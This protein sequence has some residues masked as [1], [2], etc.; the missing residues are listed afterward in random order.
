MSEGAVSYRHWTPYGEFEAIF[1]V[2]T[3]YEVWFQTTQMERPRKIAA[4]YYDMALFAKAVS[5]GAYAEVGLTKGVVYLPADVKAW[6]P[7][8]TG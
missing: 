5:D 8:G 3:G 6:Q 1:I 2:P 7:K 4:G